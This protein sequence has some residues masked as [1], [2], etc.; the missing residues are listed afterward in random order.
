MI[1]FVTIQN[2]HRAHPAPCQHI[3]PQASLLVQ[4]NRDI[5]AHCYHTVP[6]KTKALQLGRH[7]VSGE[8]WKTHSRSEVSRSRSYVREGSP[9]FA[10]GLSTSLPG[11]QSCAYAC[12]RSSRQDVLYRLRTDAPTRGLRSV[13]PSFSSCSLLS[14]FFEHA[15]REFHTHNVTWIS[16]PPRSAP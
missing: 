13:K 14:V 1:A 15:R 2:L 11:L 12:R 4:V 10:T 8:P 6:S 7:S 9:A 3:T 16:F 5:R